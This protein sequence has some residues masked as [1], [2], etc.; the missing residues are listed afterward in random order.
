M[1]VDQVVEKRP[2]N[3]EHTCYLSA[4]FFETLVWLCLL[5]GIFTCNLFGAANGPG[6]GSL[7]GFVGAKA[8]ML[9]GGLWDL[10]G[11]RRPT[12]DQFPQ[13]AP[14]VGSR[15][16]HLEEIGTTLGGGWVN[17]AKFTG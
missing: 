10:G 9:R 1:G 8:A 5:F 7:R 2:V 6:P 13:K 15:S 14:V 3:Q 16:G 11:I 12:E 17:S 4:C